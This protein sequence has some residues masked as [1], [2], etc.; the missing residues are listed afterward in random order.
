MKSLVPAV[1]MRYG[2]TLSLEIV[3]VVII[4]NGHFFAEKYFMKIDLSYPVDRN[5]VSSE[6]RYGQARLR[7]LHTANF[8]IWP[9][10]LVDYHVDESPVIKP[11][12]FFQLLTRILQDR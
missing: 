8:S 5:D 7:Q 12:N 1:D 10:L 11:E 9:C 4:A 3:L 2:K 6:S